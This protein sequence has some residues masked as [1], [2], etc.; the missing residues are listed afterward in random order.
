MVERRTTGRDLQLLHVKHIPQR[1]VRM[2]NKTRLARTVA[3]S[4]VSGLV[5]V[6][7]STLLFPGDR[8]LSYL[9]GVGSTVVTAVLYY[10]RWYRDQ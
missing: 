3:V 8:A 1:D 4:L 2:A 7:G 6:G 10:T 5:G 9:I